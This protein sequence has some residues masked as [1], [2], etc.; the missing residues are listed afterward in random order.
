MKKE[1]WSDSNTNTIKMNNRTMF[2]WKN[3]SIHANFMTY[4]LIWTSH[5]STL[6]LQKRTVWLKRN[7]VS[8][9]FVLQRFS[10]KI[11]N[12]MHI[13]IE[14]DS[15]SSNITNFW[16][17]LIFE[18]IHCNDCIHPKSQHELE[19]IHEWSNVTLISKCSIEV[20]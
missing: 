14:W 16:W 17:I 12:N 9:W 20:E 4:K 18:R 11:Q 3:Y 19:S 15:Q 13:S 8:F 2:E 1:D 5:V 6:M 10:A 7:F